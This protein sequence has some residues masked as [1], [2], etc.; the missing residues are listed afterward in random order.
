MQRRSRNVLH[1]S[2]TSIPG[3]NSIYRVGSGG[4]SL[5]HDGVAGHLLHLHHQPVQVQRNPPVGGWDV[6][7]HCDPQL[8]CWLGQLQCGQC[9][10]TSGKVVINTEIA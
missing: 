2:I 5:G 7:G 8:P 3:R 1:H 10:W 4:H 9:M 6:H